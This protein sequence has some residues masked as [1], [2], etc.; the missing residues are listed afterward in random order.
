MI[1]NFNVLNNLD[2]FEL[3]QVKSKFYKLEI[4]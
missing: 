4:N 2:E 3:L 1:I